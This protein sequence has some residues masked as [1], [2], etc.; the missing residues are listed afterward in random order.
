MLIELIEII[1]NIIENTGY[2]GMCFFMILESMFFPVP[3]EA[4]MPFAGYLIGSQYT[5]LGVFLSSTM[6]SLIGSYLSYLIGQFGGLPLLKKYGH[7]VLMTQKKLDSGISLFNKHG[8]KTIFVSRFIPVV[9]HVI[10]IPAGIAHMNLPKFFIYT[11]IGASLWNMF[12]AYIGYI[13]QGN[14]EQIHHYKH[15]LDIAGILIIIALLIYL[16]IK[17]LKQ[18]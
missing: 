8:E 13:C 5:W 17:K 18:A 6:G 10:S 1:K 16:L 3:S 7:Y 9:R 12:L 2:L 11:G 4:V 15:Y 14:I